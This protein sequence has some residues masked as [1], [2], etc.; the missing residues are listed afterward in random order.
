VGL[1]VGW[2]PPEALCFRGVLSNS[3][4]TVLSK[5]LGDRGETDAEPGRVAFACSTVQD[6]STI[7]LVVV[8]STLAA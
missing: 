7:V 3:S 5:V 4:S 1:L 2:R 6:L 8:L